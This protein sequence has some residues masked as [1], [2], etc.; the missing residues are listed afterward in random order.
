MQNYKGVSLENQNVVVNQ[1]DDVIL[2]TH[3]SNNE[4]PKEFKNIQN[5][6]TANH[7]DGLANADMV[8]DYMRENLKEELNLISLSEAIKRENIDVEILNKIRFFISNQ[9][10]DPNLFKID[11]NTGIFYNI[12]ENSVFEVRK[13]EQTGNYEIYKGGEF[14]YGGVESSYEYSD[15][16]TADNQVITEDTNEKELAYKNKNVKVRKLVRPNDLNN[17][18]FAKSSLLFVIILFVTIIL[19][20]ALIR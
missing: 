2:K 19:T 5:E 3:N 18:A 7:Q 15:E 14:V 12:E 16:K 6:I 4:L 20:V 8:F 1:K 13:N 10:V 11:L 9:Y 17:A